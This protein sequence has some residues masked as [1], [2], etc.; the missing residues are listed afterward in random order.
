M[1]HLLT[2][3]PSPESCHRYIQGSRALQKIFKAS[4]QILPGLSLRINVSLRLFSRCR[5]C[6]SR[7]KIGNQMLKSFYLQYLVAASIIRR[8]LNRHHRLLT[9]TSAVRCRNMF[10]LFA[11]HG[12]REAGC[13]LELHLPQ[14]L[15]IFSSTLLVT[16]LS[17]LLRDLSYSYL[18]LGSAKTTHCE[19]CS[20]ADCPPSTCLEMDI[21]PF[22]LLRPQLAG[23][24]NSLVD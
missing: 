18:L 11:C 14:T 2:S 16:I 20:T 4:T 19:R 24:C 15:R 8:D 9:S 12:V 22:R 7:C 3:R 23:S 6:G 13:C 17:R 21:N 1:D 10:Q 5:S